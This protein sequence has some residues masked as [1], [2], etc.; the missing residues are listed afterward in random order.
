MQTQRG[1]PFDCEFCAA[2]I[3]LSPGFKVKP[4]DK[5]IAE[6]RRIRE[7]WPVSSIE[8]ADDN[9]FANKKHG[10]R[11]L[12]ALQPERI[13]WFTETDISVAED[14][15]LLDLMRD[16]GCM[17]VL[18][19]FESVTRPGLTGVE[20]KANWKARQLD[21]YMEG[22][23]RIQQRGIT[24]NGCFVLGLDG[25]GHEEFEAVAQF[26]KD[27]GLYDVQ[28]TVLT[29]FPGTPLYHR[30]LKEG[31]LLKEEAWERCTLFD[32]NF[33]PE[34]MSVEELEAGF[35]ELARTLYDRASWT[36]RLAMMAQRF[37]SG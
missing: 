19:G 14:D 35:L 1:C 32:V 33:R 9:T 15:E 10:K 21:R 23:A 25:T 18:V 12:R 27:S 13:R 4:V 3:R 16:S 34:R 31:R 2:S 17:Q 7:I 6:V 26:V 30:L 36:D 22:I 20:L 37:G 29:P 8:F 11:L 28:I 5:V 24:V